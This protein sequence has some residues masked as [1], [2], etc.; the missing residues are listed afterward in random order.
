MHIMICISYMYGRKSGSR[1]YKSLRNRDIRK[2]REGTCNTHQA[3]R[4]RDEYDQWLVETER[5]RRIW[6][7]ERE[8]ERER[9]R[10]Q[11][12]FLLNW[13][14]ACGRMIR[15]RISMRVWREL[16]PGGPGEGTS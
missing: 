10:A 11:D 7:R 1:A 6:I 2:F 4:K 16:L 8:R 15:L 12:C 13:W 14:V 9:E 3:K 5:E